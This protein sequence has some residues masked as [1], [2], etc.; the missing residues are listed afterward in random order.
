MS[1]S[2]LSHRFLFCPILFYLI[3][4][5]PILSYLIVFHFILFYP[6]L[7]YLILSCLTLSFSILHLTI[8]FSTLLYCP[9]LGMTIVCATNEGLHAKCKKW[10]TERIKFDFI[11]SETGRYCSL[12]IYSFT[13]ILHFLFLFH[14]P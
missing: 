8:L 6:K 13:M 7:S 2:V 4:S 10:N 3:L 14:F 12:K 11:Q 5:Y 1:Y 9:P